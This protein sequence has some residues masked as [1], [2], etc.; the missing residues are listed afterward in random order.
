MRTNQSETPV[1]DEEAAKKADASAVSVTP[2]TNEDSGELT[3]SGLTDAVNAVRVQ[4]SA[5]AADKQAEADAAA[6]EGTE[7]NADVLTGG[8][9]TTPTAPNTPTERVEASGVSLDAVIGQSDD[10][11]L[12]VYETEQAAVDA[13]ASIIDKA[14]SSITPMLASE[15][16]ILRNK[17]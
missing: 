6:A 15:P 9:D 12:N 17:D 7:E 13:G 8:N 10:G 11:T 2:E 3:S 5:D 16:A 4:T 1:E 14:A